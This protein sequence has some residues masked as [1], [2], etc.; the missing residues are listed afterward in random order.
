MSGSWCGKGQ[1]GVGCE[2]LERFQACHLIPVPFQ[3]EGDAGEPWSRAC[4]MGQPDGGGR[5]RAPGLAKPS[6]PSGV[7]RSEREMRHAP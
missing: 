2:I 4:S 5:D 7:S 1:E 3:R 6:S